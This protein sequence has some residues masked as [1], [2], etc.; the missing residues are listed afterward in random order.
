MT[1]QLVSLLKQ[2]SFAEFLSSVGLALV[3]IFCR[4]CTRLYLYIIYFLTLN[5]EVESYQIE[6]TFSKEYSASDDSTDGFLDDVNED[7]IGHVEW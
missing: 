6:P 7:R 5:M 1:S 3:S 2:S 4:R